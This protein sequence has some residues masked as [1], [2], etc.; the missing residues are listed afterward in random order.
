MSG[1]ILQDIQIIVHHLM[2]VGQEKVHLDA[3][4]AHLLQAGHLFF[5]GLF[6]A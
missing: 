6:G 1:R 4:G 5:A 3:G 2:A